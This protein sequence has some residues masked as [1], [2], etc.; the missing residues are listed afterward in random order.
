ML[1]VYIHF[2]ITINQLEANNFL[3]CTKP[4]TTLISSL[5]DKNEFTKLLLLSETHRRLTCFI[6]A[7]SETDMPHLRPIETNMPHRRPTCLMGDPSETDMPD[8]RPIGDQYA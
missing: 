3:L 4:S 8:W 1:S 6:D 7:P 5:S 2:L